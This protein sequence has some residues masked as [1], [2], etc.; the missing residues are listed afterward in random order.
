ML[1]G[2]VVIQ[3][4]G[5][6]NRLQNFLICLEMFPGAIGML[7]AFPWTEYKSEGEGE[8]SPLLWDPTC[9]C[10]W[11]VMMASSQSRFSGPIDFCS[12]MEA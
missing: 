11:L 5:D 6:G 2:I 8:S 4:A 3:T 1:I 12:T 7:F 9:S 10:P